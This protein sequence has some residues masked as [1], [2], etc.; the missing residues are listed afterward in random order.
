MSD[1]ERIIDERRIQLAVK[2]FARR[3]LELRRKSAAV[4]AHSARHKALVEPAQKVRQPPAVEFRR[5]HLEAGEALQYAG[6]DQ[7]R[8][9]EF[10]LVGIDTRGDGSLLCVRIPIYPGEAGEFVQAERHR[11]L[12]SS[13]PERIINLGMERQLFRG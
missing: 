7:C 13:R 4:H 3:Q 1:A 2:I 12:L 6:H 9:S 8:K 11:E 5:Y 10:N